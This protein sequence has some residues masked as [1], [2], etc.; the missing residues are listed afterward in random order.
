MKFVI[1]LFIGAKAVK[2]EKGPSYVCS[3]IEGGIENLVTGDEKNIYER[4]KPLENAL[5]SLELPQ[6]RPTED[7]ESD[8]DL[9]QALGGE[10]LNDRITLLP[11][12]VDVTELQ[13]PD[14]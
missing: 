7:F 14:E 3:P 9:D 2:I 8:E 13:I 4:V 11:E 5:G 10:P 6:D 1:A 12:Q